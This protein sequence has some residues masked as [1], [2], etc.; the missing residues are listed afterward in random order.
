MLRYEDPYGYPIYRTVVTDEYGCYSDSYVVTEG[1]AWQVTAEYPGDD[2]SGPALSDN[3]IVSVPLYQTGDQDGDTVPDG[4]EPQG[5]HD[6]DGL[7]G[8]FDP[9]S[10][11]DG[12]NDGEESAG[13]CDRDGHDNIVDTDSDNDGIPDGQDSTPCGGIEKPQKPHYRFMYSFH[14]GSTHPVD[15]LDSLADAN[16]NF[17]IDASYLLNDRFNLKLMLGINQFTAES[18]T[19][20]DHPLWINASAN[21]QAVFPT[22]TGLKNYLQVGPGWYKPKSGSSEFGF[23]IGVGWQIPIPALFNLEFGLD[24]HQIQTKDPTRFITAHLGVLF[25]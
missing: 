5:D 24:F 6:R 11:G 15:N 19:G 22:S 2:C 9:D 14:V 13:D 17:H 12:L 4:E 10:D 16:I 21:I 3:L 23:N 7:V 18:S 20:I 8:K 25:R 1:G